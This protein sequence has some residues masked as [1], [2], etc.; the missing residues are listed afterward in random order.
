[1]DTAGSVQGSQTS[2]RNPIAATGSTSAPTVSGGYPLP[3]N[4]TMPVSQIASVNGAMPLLSSPTNFSASP[5]PTPGRREQRFS[6]SARLGARRSLS[7]D[8]SSESNFDYA[9]G[10]RPILRTI[11]VEASEERLFGGGFPRVTPEAPHHVDRNSLRTNTRRSDRAPAPFLHNDPSISSMGSNLS[12][13][14]SASSMHTPA[15]PIDDPRAQRYIEASWTTATNPRRAGDLDQPPRPIHPPLQSHSSPLYPTFSAS[16]PMT[17]AVSPVTNVTKES[18]QE[19]TL[20]RN[21]SLKDSGL[22]R[23]ESPLDPQGQ[24]QDFEHLRQPNPY[25]LPPTTKSGPEKAPPVCYEHFNETDPLSVLAYAGRLLDEEAR[26]P[27]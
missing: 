14:T 2:S 20:L 25:F 24:S 23:R 21:L 22:V 16:R 8:E 17:G 19:R 15:T 1:M 5:T 9:P 10:D 18:S 26:K 27:P 12:F 13:A 7:T 11:P 6:P 3:I 4:T